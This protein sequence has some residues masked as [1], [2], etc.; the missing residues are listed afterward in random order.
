MPTIEPGPSL[1]HPVLLC[2]SNLI[3]S[4][5]VNS[6]YMQYRDSQKCLSA[7]IV[8]SL[9]LEQPGARNRARSFSFS[10]GPSL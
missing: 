1:F 2:D 6:N 3:P 4:Q 10:S 9:E 8:W 7:G 5:D